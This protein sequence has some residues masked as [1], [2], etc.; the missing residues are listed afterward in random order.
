MI[1]IH[2]IN[3]YLFENESE[4]KLKQDERK[5]LLSDCKLLV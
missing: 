3:L 4:F 2:F 5:K 1:D